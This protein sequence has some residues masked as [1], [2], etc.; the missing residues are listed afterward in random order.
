MLRTQARTPSPS[1]KLEDLATH[2]ELNIGGKH[3]ARVEAGQR[4]IININGGRCKLSSEM[5]R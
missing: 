1:A 4:D 3:Q 5:V 2:C